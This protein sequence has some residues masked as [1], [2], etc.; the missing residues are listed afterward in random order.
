MEFDTGEWTGDLFNPK[1]T[2][3]HRAIKGISPKQD[4]III[5]TINL[6]NPQITDILKVLKGLKNKEIKSLSNSILSL[7]YKDLEHKK[8]LSY[9]ELTTIKEY[10]TTKISNPQKYK[11]FTNIKYIFEIKNME[12]FLNLYGAQRF[13]E[14]IDEKIFDFLNELE[15]KYRSSKLDLNTVIQLTNYIQDLKKMNKND[16]IKTFFETLD[17]KQFGRYSL[18]DLLTNTLSVCSKQNLLFKKQFIS[19]ILKIIKNETK[20][21]KLNYILQ[22]LKTNEKT[23]ILVSDKKQIGLISDYL[24]KHKIASTN[25]TTSIEPQIFSEDIIIITPGLYSEVL[26]KRYANTLILYD[27]EKYSQIDEELKER[28]DKIIKLRFE[29]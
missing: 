13:L 4:R 23:I 21:A 2:D 3:A 1:N 29:L 15:K 27:G 28:F 19:S 14:Y 20:D 16:R 5:E 6:K 25:I 11:L 7:V 24:A 18:K 8:D 12:H 22:N 17:I 9:D 26:H 10:L